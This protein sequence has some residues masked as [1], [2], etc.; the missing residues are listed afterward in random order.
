MKYLQCRKKGQVTP[1]D[2]NKRLKFARDC[3]K[4]LPKD[5]WT[6]GISFYLD[7][8]SWA[9]K[10][11]PCETAKTNR[12]RT[13]RKRSEGLSVFCTAK[14]KEE[15]VGNK[16]AKFFVAVSYKAGVVHVEHFD[17]KVNGVNFA[18][19]VTGQFDKIF[20]KCKDKHGKEFL[21]DGDP[22]QNSAVARAAMKRIKCKVFNIPARS[23]DI[24]IIENVFHLVGKKIR[25]DA[26][27]QEITKETFQ[28][29][30]ARCKRTLEEF[31]A[32]IIDRT[33]ESL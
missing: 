33:I 20:E 1:T 23:P 9:H 19:F 7:G 21:Q 26:V 14:G 2:M 25:D 8:V 32:D 24:N 11:D 3:K 30:V 4:T 22:S 12:T 10:T 27:E 6:H 29:F 16:V 17:R 13:W 18:D 31:P 15:G 5:F 28:E